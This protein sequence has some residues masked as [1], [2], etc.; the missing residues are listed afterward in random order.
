[1][2]YAKLLV[3]LLLIVFSKFG[4]CQTEDITIG[5]KIHFHSDILNEDREIWIH[6]PSEALDS[7]YAPKSYPVL[8]LLDG[9]AHFYS[10]MG[11]MRQL[12][13]VNGNTLL[14][15]MIIVGITN[16]NRMLD[17]TPTSVSGIINNPLQEA[18]TGGGEK[19]LDFLEKELIP[20]I[21]SNYPVFPYRTFVGHS[22]GGL[23]VIHTMHTRPWMF[24]NYLAIDP[25]L[26][27]DNQMELKNAEGG[28]LK[29][30]KENI[31]VYVAIANT[32][33][34][35]WDMETV[36]MD[37]TEETEHYRSIRT[38]V[39]LLDK[40]S[41]PGLKHT[42]YYYKND[43]HGSVPLIAEY[44]G[45]RFFN[46]MFQIKDLNKLFDQKSG[47]GSK[48]K[49]EFIQ[50]HYSELGHALNLKI[51]PDEMLVNQ[52]AYGFLQ[53][54]MM[55]DA[56]LFF[57]WNVDMYPESSNAYDSLGDYYLAQSDVENAKAMY[58]VAIKIK[59]HPASVRKLEEL[60]NH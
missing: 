7:L 20:Y 59:N 9:D 1:M 38:Y 40:T 52:L 54:G 23:M 58:R 30:G 10:V 35:S 2:N 32:I 12:S 14:P 4:L 33:G 36:M 60:E 28:V 41:N 16:T 22:L 51:S 21:E 57:K 39:D 34:E 44:N 17:L 45:L 18:L 3:C 50:D 46:E 48:D 25:S 31:Q 43:D 29:A 5:S 15:K 49:R 37:T 8:Y 53:N 24:K 19:F 27:W 55:E 56:E 11:M 13:S 26:W 47:L 6:V 42:W